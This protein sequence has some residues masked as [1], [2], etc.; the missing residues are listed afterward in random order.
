MVVTRFAPS[1]T[2]YL[3]VGSAR[4]AYYSWLFARHAGGSFLLRIEDTDQARSSEASAQGI[5][6]DMTWLGLTWDEGP[7]IAH[8]K[9]GFFQ[10]ARLPRYDAVIQDLLARGLAYEA[11][12]T[13]AELGA[14][15]KAADLEKRAFRYRHDLPGRAAQTPGAPVVIRFKTPRV[16]VTVHDLI[17]GAVTI[18]ADEQDDFVIKKSDGFPTFHLAVVVDDHDMGVTHVL[19]SQEHLPNT[20]KHLAI[21]NAMNWTPPAHGHL[22]VV[23]TM[24]AT[25]MSKRDKARAAREAIKQHVHHGGPPDYS[26]LSAKTGMST[27]EIAD[28]MARKTEAAELAV[29]L[30]DALGV[31]LPEIDVNDFRKSGYLPEALLNFIALVGW[32]PGADREILSPTQIIELF[33]TEGVQKTNGKFDRKKLAWMNGEYIRQSTLERLL[34]A[35]DAFCA[36]TDYPIKH[37]DEPTRRALLAM[38][39]ERMVSLAEMAQNSCFF[40]EEPTYD[41]KAVDKHINKNNGVDFLKA[42]RAILDP[43]S[44]WT[45]AGLA[46]P[47]ETV[48]ALGEK[49][50]AAA[51]AIRVALA[52]GPV[53]PP[54]LE[55]IALLGRAKTFAR[56]DAMLT[57]HA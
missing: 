16:D 47:M 51:Q 3:H 56:I 57:Q 14:L 26:D 32:A 49:K 15:R 41:A 1:P 17:R 19:R 37:A 11:Y 52:G 45:R 34:T 10:S 50:G 21:Y 33:S 40:F 29:R 18:V 39:Q 38:Y 20:T 28:F 7:I 8:G 4:T 42:A 46:G 25:K 54:L 13:T 12:E 23:F 31:A 22:P 36:V 6:Q 24:E 43:V 30:A 27:Q 44:D 5:L 48:L 2:G 55:T 35:L 9:N 53:S